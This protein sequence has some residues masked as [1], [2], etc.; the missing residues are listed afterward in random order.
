LSTSNVHDMESIKQQLSRITEV[1]PPGSQIVYLDYPV[2]GN[3]G[4]LLIMKGTE[5]FFRAHRIRVRKRYSYLQFRNGKKFPPDWIIVFQGG[6]NFGDLYPYFQKLRESVVQAYPNHRVV[7]LPQTVHF[8]VRAK[9]E[10]SLR[11]FAGHPDFHLYVRDENSFAIAAASIRNVYLSPDMAHQLYPVAAQKPQG[12]EVLAVLR[13]DGEIRPQG[14]WDMR[15][16]KVSDWPLLLSGWDRFV[17]RLM[18]KGCT[19]DRLL[20]N[21]LP[22]KSVWNLLSDRYVAKAVKLFSGPGRVITSRLHGHILACLMDIPNALI[23][24]SYGKNMSYYRL[25]TCRVE[26]ARIL[27]SGTPVLAKG[28]ETL[29]SPGGFDDR[30]LRT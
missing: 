26:G 13:T 24:N 16:D 25:W 19:L 5:A 21:V 29:E 4:D 18:V 23:D 30:H 15:Y 2:H 28:E 10:H 3:I 14:P 17:I 8:E 1:I 11:I 20:G 22:V 7:V 12:T 9:E 27:V 6:G